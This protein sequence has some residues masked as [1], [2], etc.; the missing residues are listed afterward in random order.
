MVQM[1]IYRVTIIGYRVEEVQGYH[2]GVQCFQGELQGDKRHNG[3][4]SSPISIY[5]YNTMTY[6]VCS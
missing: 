3:V 1:K 5:K 2:V 6:S 4:Q